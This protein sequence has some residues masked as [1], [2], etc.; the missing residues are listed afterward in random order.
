M[1]SIIIPTLGNR[2]V[3]LNRLMFSLQNQTSKQF[4]VICAV[5]DNHE[6][7]KSLMGQYDLNIKVIFFR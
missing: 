3:E 7:V 6:S 4:E 1:L 5:Q 2:L